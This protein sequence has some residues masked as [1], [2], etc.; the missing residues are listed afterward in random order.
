MTEQL[1]SEPM[2]PSAQPSTTAEVKKCPYCAE[3]I[4]AEAVKCR[5]CSEF[6]YGSNRPP[7]KTKDKKWYH[8][9]ST[10]VLALLCLGPLALPLVWLNPRY[11]P[12]TKGLITIIV[13]VVTILCVY[14]MGAVYQHLLDQLQ[15]LGA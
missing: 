13:L 4:Q 8:S 9:N 14:L 7:Y 3:S 5:Y 11:K 12:L 2:E 10:V 6:L 15:A 1:T